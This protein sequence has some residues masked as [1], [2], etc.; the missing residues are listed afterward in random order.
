[1]K[2]KLRVMVVDDSRLVLE[3]VRF[4]LESSGHTVEVRDSALGT[5]TAVFQHRPHVL[6]LDVSMP[7]VD[8]DRLATLVAE[9]KQD[10]I[11]I[12]HSSLDEAALRELGRRCGAHGVIPK[13]HDMRWFQSAFDRIVHDE[14]DQRSR[15]QAGRPAR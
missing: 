8:G 3:R 4:A 9:V 14:R 5:V 13:S 10:I 12:L 2:E 7:S 6:V 11:L 1:M 15:R